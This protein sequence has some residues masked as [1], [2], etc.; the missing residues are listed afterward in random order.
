MLRHNV[1]SFVRLSGLTIIMC[2]TGLTISPSVQA[3]TSFWDAITAGKFDFSARYRFEHV[4]DD[5]INTATGLKLKDAD[6]STIRTTLGYKTGQFHHFGAR[7]LL[8]DVRDI[9]AD[10]FNDATGKSSKTAFAVVADPSDTDFLE[11]Y[12]SFDGLS[13]TV[14]KA[15]R[16]IITYRDAPFHRYMGTILWRQNW[17]NHD[18]VS[19]VNTALPDT[20]ISYAYSWNIN[21][22]FTDEAVSPLNEFDSNSHF[23]NLKYGG[24]SLGS[25]EAYTYLL[26]FDNAVAFSTNTYGARFNGAH[27]VRDNF[28][29]IY[30]AEY[31]YQTD[32]ANNPGEID[33]NY[34]LGELGGSFNFTGPVKT[35]TVKF[36]YELQEG[37]GGADR[38]VTILGTNHA[39]QGWADRFVTTPGDGVEDLYVTFVAKFFGVKF[40]ASYHDLNS[41][42]LDYDYGEELDLLL[43]KTFY[44]H[45]TAGLKYADYDADESLINIT[46]N[47]ANST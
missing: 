38:F 27:P 17:Q 32:A 24:F 39:Y 40:I 22:I 11:A 29:L 12:L 47:G 10:N 28:K 31:A 15:G 3:E 30:T 25:L 8:Q 44:K 42:N 4:E 9:G 6:A 36:S 37:E 21:R 2:S 14:I 5:R 20:R 7:L 46:Q 41:D 13:D 33:A 1:L 34:F 18:A 19:L 43:T 35:V 26:D 16:Q 23:I 45:Y